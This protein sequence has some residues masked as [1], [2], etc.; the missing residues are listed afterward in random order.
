MDSEGKKS[1]LAYFFASYYIAYK[2]TFHE[3]MQSLAVAD[4]DQFPRF[5]E[6]CLTFS[7]I[8]FWGS[9]FQ[10]DTRIWKLSISWI[11]LHTSQLRYGKSSSRF[12]GLRWSRWTPELCSMVMLLF[13][14]I[15]AANTEEI[16]WS[17]VLNTRNELITRGQLMYDCVL[18]QENLHVCII[19][20]VVWG[21]AIKF[22]SY[23][24][25]HTFSYYCMNSNHFN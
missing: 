5:P 8:S 18:V 2:F 22:N 25:I 20:Q 17:I 23:Q 16:H 4:P 1:P 6:T 12:A 13:A 11:N 9:I 14:S 3:R 15:Q 7:I 10:K 21:D 24:F 19:D